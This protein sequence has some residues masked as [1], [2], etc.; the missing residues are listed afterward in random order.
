MSGRS[1]V[2]PR[3]LIVGCALAAVAAC[4]RLPREGD[5][6]AA[7]VDSSAPS[8]LSHERLRLIP[9][10]SRL[11]FESPILVTPVDLAVA[12]PVLVV[13][14]SKMNPGSRFRGSPI[15]HIRGEVALDRPRG[16][17]SG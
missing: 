11:L 6:E 16:A 8:R 9:T 17:G 2:T 1:S 12:G 15:A 13:A 4:E 3:R 14:D 5:L 10:R 7:L